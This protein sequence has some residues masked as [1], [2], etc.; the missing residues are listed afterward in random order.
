[1]SHEGPRVAQSRGTGRLTP[2]S[3]GVLSEQRSAWGP[4][5]PR[6]LEGDQ[7]KQVR[8]GLGKIPSNTDG[9]RGLCVTNS[10]G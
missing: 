5:V 9:L 6:L 4:G 10:C 1:M 8:P 3:W 2:S 7:H